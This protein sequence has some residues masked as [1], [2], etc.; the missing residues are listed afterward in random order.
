MAGTSKHRWW[1]HLLLF[2]CKWGII[3]GI[4][5]ITI[6]VG[7]GAI[8]APT[9]PSTAELEA[10]YNHRSSIV[11]SADGEVIARLGRRG[12]NWMSLDAIVPPVVEALIATEDMRFYE[13]D[14]IDVR[15]T[16]AAGIFTL[17]GDR[18][19]GSTITQQLVR[20]MYPESIGS[21]DPITRKLKEIITARKLESIY[22]KNEILEL[23]LN[24]VPFLYN[25]F[26]IEMAAR[27]YFD[28]SA[29]DL[30]L[31]ESA[32][33]VGMLKG[34]ARY[35][36]VHHPERARSRR[37]VVLYQMVKHGTLEPDRYEELK[38]DPLNT[39]F[40]SHLLRDGIA[41]HLANYVER[42]AKRWAD[43][44]GYNIFTDGL[45]IQTTLDARLQRMA[46]AAVSR[47]GTALQEVAD[48]E[49]GRSTGQ[50]LSTNVEVYGRYHDNIDPFGTFWQTHP[51]MLQTFIR[52][53][54]RYQ[55]GIDRGTAPARMLDSL[56]Q[57]KRFMDSLRA[58]KTR[59]EIGFTAIEP[60]TGYVRAWVGSRNFLRGQYDHVVSARRQ[61][62]S[63][64]KPFVYAAALER[65]YAP[66]D[67]MADAPITITGTDGES[68]RPVNAGPISGKN[69]TLRTALAHS[70]NTV[71]AR[72]TE[73]I[74][75]SEVVRTA[76]RLGVNKSTLQSVP[77]IGLGTSEVTLLEMVSAYATIANRGTH[78]EPLVISHIA[79]STGTIVA[80]FG[81]APEQAVSDE[82]A[83]TL[84]DMMRGVIDEG[85][86]RAVRHRFN[87][88]ADL[89]GKTGTTQHGADGWFIMAHPE[90]TAG[91]WVGFDDPRITFRSDYW[92]QGGHNGLYVVSDFFQDAIGHDAIASSARFPDPPRGT[93]EDSPAIAERVGR[94]IG[95]VAHRITD[96]LS[97]SDPPET[98]VSDSGSSDQDRDRPGEPDSPP[99]ND[100]ED[101]EHR[102]RT[103]W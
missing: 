17:V 76:R 41:P 60:S 68:W 100:A 49:W 31:L 16:V 52:E 99:S 89:I 103:G 11:R 3:A 18:Q 86:G 95:T 23:Y 81:S 91:S 85:T 15:R 8:L 50:L 82:T 25:A 90:L 20:N 65:G 79:D 61:P 19:G 13:H 1:V 97:G 4:I 7:Y 62:G 57:D 80:E 56:R 75:P 67:S 44:N 98:D 63:T 58:A 45:T 32:T 26:G 53:S 69:V 42:Q 12:R 33:L 10:F 66:D 101:S 94:W 78:L 28:K 29:A 87:L 96:A 93:R 36:P 51:E 9:T 71:T 47:W 30:S 38:E 64:F 34:P 2:L 74:D 55:R 102:R 46:S 43:N 39:Q 88:S 5:T 72:L 70:K 59:L 35:N 77:S 40:R 37:N 27:T 14:G 92:G 21:A 22:T 54:D 24:T 83:R 84:I 48:V 6:L 73:E